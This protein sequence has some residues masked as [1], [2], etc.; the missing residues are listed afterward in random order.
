MSTT[1]SSNTS[2]RVRSAFSRVEFE[3]FGKVQGVFFRRDAALE[4][5]RLGL[6]GWCMNTPAGT[7]DG[8]IEGP[9]KIV[10][11]MVYWLGNVGSKRSRIA[12]LEI[13]NRRE[14]SMD[15]RQFT[16]FLVRH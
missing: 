2:P 12:R 11:E 14:I 4:A 3:V 16:S 1:P 8:C 10:D 13:K 9:A 7:V 15:D 5:E 6:H